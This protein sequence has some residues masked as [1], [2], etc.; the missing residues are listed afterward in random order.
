MWSRQIR[1][2]KDFQTVMILLQNLP[3]Q[4]W[5]DQQ[6]AELAADAYSLMQLFA[7]SKNHLTY[8]V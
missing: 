1:E 8:N 3:T 5:G 4:S 6:I 7:G 2:E